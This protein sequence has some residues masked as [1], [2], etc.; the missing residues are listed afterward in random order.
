MDA[1]E[2]ASFVAL[3][4][5]MVSIGTELVVGD[6]RRI[7]RFPALVAVASVAQFALLPPLAGAI[8][9]LL[10]LDGEV[11]VG[12]LILGACPAGGFSNLY[13]Y[14]GRGHLALSVTATISYVFLSAI[15]IWLIGPLVATI[16]GGSSLTPATP[17]ATA[18]TTGIA[19]WFTQAKVAVLDAFGS[20]IVRPDATTTWW[21]TTDPEEIAASIWDCVDDPAN[22]AGCVVFDPWS[23]EPGC[24]YSAAESASWGSIKAMYR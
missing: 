17:A 6:F 20:L 1:F 7:A 14:A 8:S 4:L 3:F 12:M 16:F 11:L 13:T 18:P 22:I 2:T 21:G 19:A 15:L 9:I 24:G 5:L 10:E 23:E